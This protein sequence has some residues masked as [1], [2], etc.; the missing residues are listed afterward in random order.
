MAGLLGDEI[1]GS[2]AAG[3]AYGSTSG[4]SEALADFCV[5]LFAH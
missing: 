3:L 2:G 5:T 4:S 1:L